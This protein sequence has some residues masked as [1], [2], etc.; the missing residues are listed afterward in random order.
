[1]LFRSRITDLEIDQLEV[2]T[3]LL[4]KALISAML[5][6]H[7]ELYLPYPEVAH[8]FKNPESRGLISHAANFQKV[9]SQEDMDSV[10]D[11]D[12]ALTR[13]LLTPLSHLTLSDATS[14]QLPL[15]AK[16]LQSS[17]C[18]AEFEGSISKIFSAARLPT[19]RHCYVSTSG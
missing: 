18:A 12:P 5:D 13:N 11:F 17:T 8:G 2:Y 9:L 15:E 4:C 16:M 19:S 1:M 6:E 3:L 10:L 7:S 14:F